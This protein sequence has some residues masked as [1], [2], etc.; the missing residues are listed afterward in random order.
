VPEAIV[1]DEHVFPITGKDAS[2]IRKRMVPGNIEDQVVALSTLGE[3]LYCV[4]D[5]V[6]C[7]Q[8]SDHVREARSARI[9]NCA[10]VRSTGV[11]CGPARQSA[12]DSSE[13]GTSACGGPNNT[14][15]G[16]PPQGGYAGFGFLK[17]SHRILTSSLQRF[18]R[19]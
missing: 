10:A 2:T 16:L 14:S 18:T 12:S 8:R 11:P 7:A 6:V 9:L 5:D 3:V 1:S 15:A 19:R 4:V 17:R 13:S